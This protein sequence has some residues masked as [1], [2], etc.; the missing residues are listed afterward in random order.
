MANKKISALTDGGTVV[1]TDEFVIA[2]SGTSYR[3]S[4]LQTMALQS[5][6]LVNI[7]GGSI[8]GITDLAVADGGTGASSASAA[9][10]NLGVA[11]GSDVQA[12]DADLAALAALAVSGMV[13]RTGTGTAA[14]RTITAGSG[15]TVTNGNGVAGNPTIAVDIDG[16]TTE[17]TLDGAADSI[18]VYDDSAGANRKVLLDNLPISGLDAATQA[19]METGTSTT[20]A[21]TP[22]RQQYHPS[23]AKAFV[24]WTSVTTTTITSS[25]NVSSLTDN[26]T[27]DTT[28]N[29]TTAFS[30]ADSITAVSAAAGS[31]SGI[32]TLSVFT[33]NNPSYQAE[34][35]S[36]SA[37]RCTSLFASVVSDLPYQNVALY[38]DQ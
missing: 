33:K 1:S 30:S 15:I 29:L 16:T 20:V 21:V 3:I 24:R 8:A 38:G 31:A 26:G 19:E 6:S 4:G 27:G 32:G 35:P 36:T 9:R 10:T 5:S 13:V 12:Y 23:A 28:I 17:S 14:A 34:A 22:G 18:L 2:R 7:T 25:Y 11:I 37:V